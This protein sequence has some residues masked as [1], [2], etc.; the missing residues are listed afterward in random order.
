M[1]AVK[2]PGAVPLLRLPSEV[3]L[4]TAF[5]RVSIDPNA[6]QRWVLV[7]GAST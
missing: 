3:L 6:G 5:V 1:D 2:V 4:P 7:E